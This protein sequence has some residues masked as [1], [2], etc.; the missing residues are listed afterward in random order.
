[1]AKVKIS[2][3]K[4]RTRKNAER[5]RETDENYINKDQ[6]MLS[7]TVC[8]DGRAVIAFCHFHKMS[9]YKFSYSSKKPES[10]ANF[11]TFFFYPW[12]IDSGRV[13]ITHAY[14]YTRW[15]TFIRIFSLWQ[16]VFS[17][18]VALY[19]LANDIFN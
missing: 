4:G 16:K 13:L 8:M 7:C 17:F 2:V 14:T 3:R 11:H 18:H 1:M 5:N 9:I 6:C 10:N 12:S 15:D 19:S